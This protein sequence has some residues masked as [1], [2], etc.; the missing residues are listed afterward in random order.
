MPKKPRNLIVDEYQTYQCHAKSS[1]YYVLVY[2]VVVVAVKTRG[3][4]AV[5]TAVLNAR[6][7]K[8]ELLLD[9]G[10]SI[11]LPLLQNA[12][13]TVSVSWFHDVRGL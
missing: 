3:D 13:K 2:T 11:E 8:G 7:P 5:Q 1:Q 4:L 10:A 12:A 9:R 6:D